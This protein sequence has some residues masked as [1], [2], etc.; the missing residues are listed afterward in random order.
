MDLPAP[1]WPSRPMI[2][3]RGI[4]RLISFR[5]IFMIIRFGEVTTFDKWDRI[6][7]MFWHSYLAPLA[8]KYLIVDL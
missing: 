1:F 2:F 8:F 5:I 7:L 4:V 3:P 6:R